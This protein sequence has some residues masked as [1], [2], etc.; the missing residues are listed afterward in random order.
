M[1]VGLCVKCI[2]IVSYAVVLEFSSAKHPGR[3]AE[4]LG[5]QHHTCSKNNMSRGNTHSH[6][7]N[8]YSVC[9]CSPF[10]Y[11]F[12]PFAFIFHD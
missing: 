8:I 11:L 4:V 12:T 3:T 2:Q 9:L 7:E 10:H 6:S 5:M 1:E